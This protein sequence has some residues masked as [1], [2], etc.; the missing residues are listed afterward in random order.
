L[1]SKKGGKNDP[2][3][4]LIVQLAQASD[5]LLLVELPVDLLL[6]VWIVTLSNSN[7]DG[8]GGYSSV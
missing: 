3:S 1:V 5:P 7:D 2:G 6:F 4:L 8:I